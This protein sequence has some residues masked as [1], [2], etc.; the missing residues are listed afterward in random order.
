VNTWDD[1][2][3][4]H[5]CPT[6]LERPVD[7]FAVGGM[8]FSPAGRWETITEIAPRAQYAY[9]DVVHTDRTG[10]DYAWTLR[11]SARL[12]YVPSWR[13]MAHQVR[14]F[15]LTIALDVEVTG[16]RSFGHGHTLL[17]ARQVRGAGWEITDRPDGATVE[18]VPVPNKARA[19][20]EVNRRARAHAKRLGVPL[21]R[22]EA[23]AR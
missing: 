5:E 6:P 20:S 18:T 21:Y 14:V 8:F 4:E 11:T 23:G 12:P 10:P 17:T 7:E 16:A 2:P 15:D 13:A 22:P 9:T 19:R 1:E 3:R